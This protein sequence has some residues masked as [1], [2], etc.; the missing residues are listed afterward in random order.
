MSNPMPEI[1]CPCG[2]G[3]TVLYEMEFREGRWVV[4]E[5]AEEYLLQLR[6]AH[7]P[8]IDSQRRNADIGTGL[9]D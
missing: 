7:H 3:R 4:F 9:H 6:S 2:C 8:E 1:P 5:V